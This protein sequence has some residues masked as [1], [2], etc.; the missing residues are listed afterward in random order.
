MLMALILRIRRRCTEEDDA[1]DWWTQQEIGYEEKDDVT[2]SCQHQEAWAP[3]QNEGWAR[4]L[5]R[6]RGQQWRGIS[7]EQWTYVTWR[8]QNFKFNE[9]KFLRFR[10]RRQRN[11]D[12]A[13]FQEI[14]GGKAED[15]APHQQKP[16]H[17]YQRDGGWGQRRIVYRIKA[18]S[19]KLINSRHIYVH[20][21]V[22]QCI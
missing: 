2:C 17:C 20:I 12:K 7:T 22:F 3:K 1:Q 19:R 10:R 6:I 15:D 5:R 4:R 21:V 13:N 9:N 14:A 18:L 16:K 11:G 8:N